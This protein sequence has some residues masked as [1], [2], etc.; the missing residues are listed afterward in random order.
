MESIALRYKLC[1]SSRSVSVEDERIIV[2]ETDSIN[3]G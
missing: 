1:Y 3:V 2:L